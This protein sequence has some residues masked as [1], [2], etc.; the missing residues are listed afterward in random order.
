MLPKL[1]NVI[2]IIEGVIALWHSIVWTL[3]QLSRKWELLI[4]F[5]IV[6]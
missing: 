2:N 3:Y 1:D 5:L 6:I 4:K